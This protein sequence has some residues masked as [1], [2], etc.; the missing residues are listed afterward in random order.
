VPS[1]FRWD[2]TPRA[3]VREVPLQTGL[4]AHH[5]L[6]DASPVD[7]INN[8]SAPQFTRSFDDDQTNSRVDDCINQ[9]EQINVDPDTGLVK[10]L[11]VNQKRLVNDYV[12]AIVPLRNVAPRE[13][14]G[15]FR[16]V[17]LAAAAG[18]GAGW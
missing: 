7:I 17:L 14:R 1:G 9:D 6:G 8:A 15:V 16:N 18:S 10:V 12:G 5:G 3:W 2:P 13:M 4:D 11:R